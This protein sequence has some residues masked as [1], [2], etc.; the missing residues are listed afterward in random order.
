MPVKKERKAKINV[1]LKEPFYISKAYDEKI[2]KN[3]FK[4]CLLK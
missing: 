2:C 1:L 3:W 4:Y